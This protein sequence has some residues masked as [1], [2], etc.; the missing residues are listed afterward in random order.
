MTYIKSKKL[1][2]LSRLGL[3]FMVIPMMAGIIALIML[4]NKTVDLRHRISQ[5]KIESQ[6]IE[7]ERAELDMDIL[8]GF[9]RERVAEFVAAHGLIEEKHPQYREVSQ[10]EVASRY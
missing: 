9:N 4:Y 5:S 2:I 3:W 1:N 7:T 8:S 6:R 10:W